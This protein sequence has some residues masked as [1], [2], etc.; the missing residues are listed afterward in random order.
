M[1]WTPDAEKALSRA[2][3]FVRKRVRKRVEEEAVSCG[4]V[5]VTID[6]VESTRR[7]F[8]KSMDAEVKGY[9]VETCFSAAGCPNRAVAGQDLAGRIEEILARRNLREFLRDRVGGQLKMH[10]EFRVSASD[11][12]NACSRPQIADVGLIGAVRPVVADPRCTQCKAC[13]EAC[14]E[15]AIAL[16][17]EDDHPRIDETKCLAC[18]QCI[19]ACPTGALARGE[20]GYRIQIGGKLGRRPRLATELDGIHSPEH[21]LLLLE[22]LL[23]HYFAH[24]RGG[25]RFGEILER[26]GCRFVPRGQDISAPAKE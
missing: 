20:E 17:E 22:E 4:A 12:P 26:D 7:K 23:D 5:R 2:P 16:C 25:E 3:F 9:Q 24:C 21:T 18:G 15:A 11:C 13:I 8:V 10:H 1:E 6:H 19:K 14:K